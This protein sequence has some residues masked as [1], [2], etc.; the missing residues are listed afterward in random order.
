MKILNLLIQ[1]VFV[2]YTLQNKILLNEKINK[3]HNFINNYNNKR[4][5]STNN[6]LDNLI[7]IENI[8]DKV[9]YIASTKNEDGEIFITIN[10]EDSNNSKRIIYKIKSDYTYENK[11]MTINS[12]KHNKYPLFTFL[13]MEA[14]DK[15]YFVTLS[16]EGNRFELLSYTTGNI[17]Y[18]PI[19]KTFPEKSITLKNTFTNLKY[20]N[21][22]YYILNTLVDDL[23]SNFI[24]Q[25]LY[26]QHPQ[27]NDFPIEKEEKK[28][29]K[30]YKNL[31]VT[32][33][34]FENYIE[35]LYA[36]I[37]KL[38]TIT[39]FDIVS[40]NI[41]YSE[42]IE[43]IPI[44]YDELFSKCIFIKNNI[45]A[46]IYFIDKDLFPKIQFKMLKINENKYQLNNLTET[47]N[48]NSLGNFPLESNYIYNDIIKTNDNNIYYVSTSYEG[49]EIYVILI[50]LLNDNKNILLCYYSI[51]LNE[52]YNIAIY[53]DITVFS[54]NGLLGIGMT[55]F[56][57]NFGKDKLNSSFLIIGNLN[58]IDNININISEKINFSIEEE[59]YILEINS[60]TDNVIINNNFFGYELAGIRIISSLN[61]S[62][63]GFYLYSNEKANK[64]KQNEI[65]SSSDKISLKIVND[66]G[67]KLGNYT[68]EYELIIKEPKYEDFISKAYSVEYF[69][70]KDK[71]DFYNSS[72]QSDTFS[73]RKGY[74]NFLVNECYKS[75]KNCSY[76]GDNFNHHCDICS[77]NYPFFYNISN[78]I[79]CF[80][81]CPENYINSGDNI[82]M[83]ISLI[84]SN[85]EKFEKFTEDN[86]N[87]FSEVF[88][89]KN[90][91][92]NS[93]T[94]IIEQNKCKKY[95]YLDENLKITCIDGD[96]CIDEYPHLDI[97]IKNMCTNCLVKYNNKC[98]IECPENTCIKQDKGLNQCIDINNNTKVINQICFE[99]FQNMSSNIKEMSDNHIIIENIP[100]LTIYSYEIGSD[101]DYYENSKLT[102]IFF[103][104]LKQTLI[105]TFNLENNTN[106]YALIVD[107][108]SKYSN[109]S[110][111]DYGFVLL[112]ENG[113]E[114]NL[115]NINE[116]LRVN[117]SIPIA[118]LNLVN[119]NYAILFS[120]QGYDIYDKYSNFYNDFCTPGYLNDN[121]ITLEER[122]K[123]IYPNNVTKGKLNC[124]YQLSDLKNKRFIYDC[125]LIDVNINNTNNNKKDDFEI[126]E[127]DENF[128]NYITDVINYKVL[129]CK[130]LFLNIENYR[131][132]K[133]VM[134]CTTSIFLSVLLLVIFFSCGLSKI[135]IIMHN[136][137]P[138]E[139]K[140]RKLILEQKNKNKIMNNII[141]SNPNRKRNVSIKNEKNKSKKVKIDIQNLNSLDIM[142]SNTNFQYTKR[143]NLKLDNIKNTA[144]NIY[145]RNNRKK[146]T[147]KIIKSKSKKEEID[148]EYDDLPFKIA[149]RIDKR[150]IFYIFKIKITEKIK[151]IDIFVNRKIKE[152]MLSEYF[153]YLLIDLTMNA[154]L[155]SDQVV[156]HKSHNNGKLDLIIVFLL[157]ALANILSS[158]IG[159][160]LE[161]LIDFE[162]KINKI[163]DIKK[164]FVFLRV[165][166][167]ILRE[168]IVRVII[169]FLIEIFIILFCTYYMFIFFTIYYKSQMS[170]LK[171]Y[172]LSL[173]Q[174]WIINIIIAI[175]IV[176]FRKIGIYFRNIYIYNTSKYLDKNF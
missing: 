146:S 175:L 65:I 116:D 75:C 54:I 96:L 102:Y 18:S 166:K 31:S 44:K 16:Y 119:F 145:D 47:I 151:I 12:F 104:N 40:L 33:F 34:E 14:K 163:K 136:E 112:L 158:I 174:G 126:K 27:I 70:D 88:I 105:K 165:F 36:N 148:I 107:S 123:E 6:K 52:N 25:K 108:P 133:A 95:F 141:S 101:I 77:E 83:N 81:T 115:S 128:F 152:I 80:E 147:T 106:I 161:R 30:A 58:S 50:K 124:I 143:N 67:I 89:Q 82:C 94:N 57:Y 76:F 66:I 49:I 61:E 157:S 154:I 2:N 63:I 9:S 24:I 168:I 28:V 117:I 172:L 71:D 11:I 135:R 144:V 17:Y 111:K 156:Y 103:K 35:C 56:D 23:N 5:I 140:L 46:F 20:Y 113:T 170:L 1:I 160:Y 114:L 162:E 4:K 22:S 13:G 169:F 142:P 137:I 51:K 91:N 118:N 176:S 37:E 72:F 132:N 127:K 97:N 10:S 39:I 62:N 122:Q 29:G 64:I 149:I 42:I 48:I 3:N 99:N 125:K 85:E 59:N 121:D 173:L 129:I 8:N 93:I 84:N 38:Y 167:I 55:H 139:Q 7:P 15:Y 74:I 159:Y 68:I 155:Y 45:G 21:N 164:E 26:L 43:S 69:P 79:N 32:C 90:D 87:E 41:L 109:S 171:N 110:I 60:I 86:T 120:E 134:I 78:G 131:H 138:S 153:L 92:N 73:G 98:Y 130:D 19:I 53:K 100:N 150:N